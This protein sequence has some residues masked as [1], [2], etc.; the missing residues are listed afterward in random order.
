M[1]SKCLEFECQ[2]NKP[3]FQ[4]KT[5]RDPKRKIERHTGGHSKFGRR[6]R[7]QTSGRC[8]FGA[9]KRNQV[10]NEVEE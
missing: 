8:M 6:K 10:C 7:E 1:S 9:F 4:S 2:Y 3:I 5:A